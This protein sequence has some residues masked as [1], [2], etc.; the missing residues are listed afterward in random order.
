MKEDGKKPVGGGRR[1]AAKA[2]ALQGEASEEN[3]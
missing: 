2:T 3:T 1:S